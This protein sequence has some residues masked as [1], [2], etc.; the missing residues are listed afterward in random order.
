[1][2]ASLGGGS[3]P[4]W[5]KVV[6][7]AGT[8]GLGCVALAWRGADE[9]WRARFRTQ[10]RQLWPW[11]LFNAWVLAS[12]LNPWFEPAVLRGQEVL[13][14]RESWAWWPG[15]A[16]VART[17]EDLWRWNVI[18][19]APLAAALF[20]ESSAAWLR[21]WRGLG[22]VAL[23]S[24]GAG[25]LLKL[26]GSPDYLGGLLTS[27]SPRFFAQFIYPNHWAAY[28]VLQLGLWA[29]VLHH[30]SWRAAGA[31][32]GERWMLPPVAMALLLIAVLA[33]GS[34][35]GMVLAGMLFLAVAYLTWHRAQRGDSCLRQW[36]RAGVVLLLAVVLIGAWIGRAELGRRAALT[37]TQI[38]QAIE[39][40][41]ANSRLVL[42]R[43]TVRL[44]AARP[45]TGWGLGS[46]GVVFPRFNTQW[47]QDMHAPVNYR[48]AH[49][50]WL[51]LFAECGLVGGALALL[52][53]VQRCRGI[54]GAWRTD[55]A[56]PLLIALG[57]VM[58]QAAFDFPTANLAVAMTASI[59]LCGALRHREVGWNESAEVRPP[60]S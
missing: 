36:A 57:L 34:R 10:V 60:R 49:N 28:A 17:V 9:V 4:G 51:E 19:L 3:V 55:S 31:G 38:A 5:D 6:L 1:V 21:V 56:R 47:A 54:R 25:T 11:W 22:F 14:A 33:S 13:V 43:D 32:G 30:G 20:I 37:R 35:S 15:T 2:A 12:L 59:C 29:A 46:Y 27:P 8:V 26:T 53:L 40:G 23:V 58:V 18:L 7:T 39:V 42:Y 16:Q 50:D 52:T 24:A 48:D 45:F 44:I 41:T